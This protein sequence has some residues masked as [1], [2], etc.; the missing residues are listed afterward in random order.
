MSDAKKIE[1]HIKIDP[2]VNGRQIIYEF[3]ARLSPESEVEAAKQITKARRMYNNIIKVM[4]DIHAE[5]Q[6]FV[7]DHAG[8]DVQALQARIESL[9]Q[10][11]LEAKA[12]NDEPEMKRIA[13][14]RRDAR[15]TLYPLLSEARKKH[16]KE[17]I[18]RFY[19][20]I[21]NTSRCDTYHLRG[22]AVKDGL[23][24][25]TANQMLDH[26]LKAWND[27][28][29]KGNAP[30]FSVGAEKIQDTLTIQFTGAGGALAD[31]LFGTRKDVVVEFPKKG[32]RKRSYT[33]FMFR[34]G[35]ATDGCYAEGT[36]QLDR[37]FPEGARVALVRLVRLRVGMKHQ[38]KL[39]FLVSL[40]EPVKVESATRKK[41]LLALHFGWSFD[42]QGRRLA[43]V[44]D[45]GE[46]LDATLLHLPPQIEE[47]LKRSAAIQSG[48]DEKR[49]AIVP[50]VKALALP[51]LPDDDVLVVLFGKIQKSP[52]QHVSANRLHYLFKLM[53]EKDLEIPEPVEAWRKNDR[54]QWQAQVSLARTARNRRRNFY[55]Q[56]ALDWARKYETILIEMPDLKKAALKLDENT[57]EKTELAKK[58]R[59][60]R[61]LAAL[62]ELESAIK[63]AACKCGSAILKMSGEH[64][65]STCAL[66]G[67]IALQA[68][69]QDSQVQYCPDCGSTVDR[70]KNGA[71]NGWKAAHADLELLVTA[72]WQTV[73]D[74]TTQAAEKKAEKS[75]KMAEGRKA[76]RAARTPVNA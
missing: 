17:L 65:A 54:M 44:S 40:A 59:A 28:M 75:A 24:F 67:G 4:R 63:W 21:G 64:T 9:S 45:N 58:S 51:D 53:Q 68:D 41:S 50:L 30:R 2:Q 12:R 73:L 69:N 19:S 22:E 11:F 7:V 36:V 32:F 13:Q 10:Q 47:N 25:G 48:R 6:V 42:E 20:R 56:C 35:A 55:R 26:A 57:G 71:A 49:D 29:K 39:Q 72:Y 46:A 14:E 23:G 76:A 34:L 16:R 15:K 74:K 43:G 27:S 1:N 33:P 60:G 5:M 62:Y 38:Y 70:K 3:G 66:C 31:D 18:D 8:Q 52:A 61:T 37:P